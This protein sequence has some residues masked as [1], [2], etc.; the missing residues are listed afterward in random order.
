M[1]VDAGHRMLLSSQNVLTC[2]VIT[3]CLSYCAY[4]SPTNYFD[5]PKSAVL[6][7]K[8]FAFHTAVFS[9]ETP[10]ARQAIS[11]STATDFSLSKPSVYL[12]DTIATNASQTRTLPAVPGAVFMTLMG[13]FCVLFFRERR[14]LVTVFAGIFLL[15]QFGIK[16]LP[17]LTARLILGKHR[18]SLPAGENAITF[19]TAELKRPTGRSDS[20]RFIG[21]LHRLATSVSEEGPHFH[22]F[23]WGRNEPS[24]CIGQ[25]TLCLDK[26]IVHA[27]AHFAP[28]SLLANNVY[29]ESVIQHWINRS[30]LIRLFSPAFC[31]SNLSRGPPGVV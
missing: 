19:H 9:D 20:V 21:L 2:A 18:T 10:C 3:L 1:F 7:S 16:S 14:T 22:T 24:A 26:Q 5:Q 8:T 27:G 17:K 4:T 12:P 29:P 25:I 11:E 13:V 28:V 30:K 31:F 6:K 23:M 15:S